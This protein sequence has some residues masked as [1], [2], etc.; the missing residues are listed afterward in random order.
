MLLGI[1]LRVLSSL[2]CLS[3]AALLHLSHRLPFK[4]KSFCALSRPAAFPALSPFHRQW[5]LL[6]TDFQKQSRHR[7]VFACLC[8]GCPQL[9]Q[10]TAW[11]GHW[12]LTKTTL[13]PHSLPFW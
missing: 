13:L 6:G 9:S 12:F 5:S 7:P 2:W 8:R 10:G 11:L 3:V 1:L 4:G